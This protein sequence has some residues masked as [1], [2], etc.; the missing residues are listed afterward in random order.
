MTS[1]SLPEDQTLAEVAATIEAAGWWGGVYDERWHTV[2]VT[3]ENLRMLKV[4]D[5]IAQA[6]LGRHVFGP[7]SV[8]SGLSCRFGFNTPELM[9]EAFLAY[10]PIVLADTPGGRD[11][12][13]AIVDPL[14]SD[15][16]DELEPVALVS[17]TICSTHGSKIWDGTAPTM[18]IFVRIRDARGALV[19]TAMI[20]QPAVSMTTM[21]ALTSHGDARHLERMQHVA[22]A[23]R[24]PAA[25]LFA[26]LDGSTP[27][28]KRLPT[29]NYFS[30]CRRFVRV[31]DTCVIEN[32]GLIGRHAGDG[33]VAFFLAETAGS[34]SAAARACVS[35]A[36]SLQIAIREV[37]E[38]SELEPTEVVLRFGLHWGATVYVGQLT[39]PGRTE[40]VSLGEEVNEAARIEACASGGRILASKALIERLHS[41]DAKE[42]TIDVRQVSYSQLADLPSATDK[43]RRDAPAIAVCDLGT[44]TA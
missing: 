7:E 4:P 31:A 18:N 27:L 41:E 1:V 8:K 9:R 26:D 37:A 19:G 43:A 39:T 20:A 5:D 40:V 16:I 44:G 2:Y 36:R 28:A 3:S 38:R 32:G 42:L 23:D 25:I 15:L 30:F 22:T 33:V 10:G 11:E 21:A 34:E 35:A 24:R 6:A 14:Y 17:T 29:P 12:L 13:R